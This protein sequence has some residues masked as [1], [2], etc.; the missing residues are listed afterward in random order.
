MPMLNIV[1][2]TSTYSTFNAGFAFLASEVEAEYTWALRAF[3]SI[4]ASPVT[5]V[6]DR[7][8][9]LMNAIV[10][11]FS[12]ARNLL[13]IWHVN[14]N[15]VANR[16]KFNWQGDGFEDFL[17]GWN[18]LVASK[19]IQEYEDTLR[20]FEISW[21]PSNPAAVQYI[22]ETWLCHKEK[23]VCCWTNQVLHCG[24]SSTSRGEGNHFVVKRNLKIANGDFLMVFDRL[25]RFLSLQHRD[26]E[27]RKE[28]QKKKVS[29][30][31]KLPLYKG[32]LKLV[33]Q[34]AL[35]MARDQFRMIEDM[36]V[37]DICSGTLRASYGI[38]CKHEIRHMI[39]EGRRLTLQDFNDQW[40]LE[41]TV[42]SE[43]IA[44]INPIQT[45]PRAQLLNQIRSQM[46]NLDGDLLP[47]FM[48]RLQTL[49]ENA[50]RPIN[51]VLRNPVP[52]ERTR[53]R[54]RGSTN[55]ANQRERSQFEY[56]SGNRCSNCQQ[57]GHNLRTCRN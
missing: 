36:A 46:Y 54:P 16:Q 23:I 21:N 39:G 45:S 19:T 42:E 43:T 15:I 34:Y 11:V 6:T 41:R 10:N 22:Q 8:L 51:N 30:R 27:T 25:D 56:T 44:E 29:H 26:L 5:I 4:V 49:N 32:V 13:C 14:K 3:S 24:T 18:S 28:K 55:H 9:A 20:N 53:G 7:E 12:S 33:S 40:H 37:D 17:S 35:D 50:D 47:A 2:I 38:P 1:G 31:H 52:L 57:H 48:T